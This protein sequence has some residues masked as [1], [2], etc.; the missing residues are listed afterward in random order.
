MLAVHY[1]NITQKGKFGTID[2]IKILGYRTN[3][4]NRTRQLYVLLPSCPAA[5]SYKALAGK[6]GGREKV[7]HLSLL[8]P[9]SSLLS[10]LCILND[11][12][13]RQ[14]LGPSSSWRGGHS[15]PSLYDDLDKCLIESL[16]CLVLL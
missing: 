8:S 12:K 11:L 2:S 5:L 9:L 6:E 7:C 10:P 4:T 16:M 14:E 3:L 1:S 15:G 13:Q